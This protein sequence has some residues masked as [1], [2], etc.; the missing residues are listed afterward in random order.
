LVIFSAAVA[1]RKYYQAFPLS[2]S[3]KT[4][5]K[6]NDCQVKKLD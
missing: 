5:G 6:L 4:K 1:S 2:K 3:T